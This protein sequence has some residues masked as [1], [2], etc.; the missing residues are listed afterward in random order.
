M[1]GA[2]TTWLDV[3]ADGPRPRRVF[4]RL[5][6]ADVVATLV[7]HLATTAALVVVGRRPSL[8]AALVAAPLLLAPLFLSTQRLYR[9][10][11]CRVPSEEVARLARAASSLGLVMAVVLLQLR[12]ADALVVAA[13]SVVLLW[14]V[15]A[16]ERTLFRG[17]LRRVRVGGAARYPT[18]L[19]AR[20][21]RLAR[22][23]DLVGDHPGL[24]FETVAEVDV[25]A[26][27]GGVP[28]LRSALHRL[29]RPQGASAIVDFDG[30]A[31]D[32]RQQ[33]TH[34]LDDY[35]LHVHLISGF[36]AIDHHRLW[37]DPLL[38]DSMFYLDARGQSRLQRFAKRATDVTLAGL[39]LLI[40]LALLAL[41]VVSLPRGGAGSVIERMPRVG[42]GGRGFE[43]LRVRTPAPRDR[44]LLVRGLLALRVDDLPQLVNV[45]RGDMSLVGPRPAMPSEVL[46]FDGPLL[47][48]LATRPGLT[49]L[50]QVE[51]GQAASFDL[52][53]RY[54]LYYVYNWSLWLDAAIIVK[55]LVRF[56][57]NLTGVTEARRKTPAVDLAP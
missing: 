34:L 9:R 13:T 46:A 14:L 43:L 26:G 22:V 17:W 33:V 25:A 56:V 20:A 51:A 35:G 42:H 53:R 3:G 47:T 7:T 8:R 27:G 16:A 2:S 50:W 28:A 40:G 41:L 45:L 31:D 12:V 15:L 18:V 30:V 1:S 39:A 44:S 49:G 29:R 36:G 24:G 37:A 10:A 54:D 57:S 32:L 5:V 55:S 48:R 38:V 19:V 11:T 6:A 23:R 52:Y 4:V 21:D